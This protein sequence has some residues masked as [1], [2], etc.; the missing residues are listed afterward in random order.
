[1]YHLDTLPKY[2]YGRERIDKIKS[3]SGGVMVIDQHRYTPEFNEDGTERHEICEGATYH[4]FSWHQDVGRVCS[5]PNC[6]ENIKDRP[7]G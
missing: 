6:E 2:I 5:E 3:N 4:V 1:M 7:T